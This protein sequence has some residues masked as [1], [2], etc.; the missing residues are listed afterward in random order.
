LHRNKPETRKAAVEAA[1]QL[2]RDLQAMTKTS[3]GA[4]C[5]IIAL[6]IAGSAHAQDA[7]V[8]A[9][10]NELS[11][12]VVTAQRTNQKLQDVPVSVT[13]VGAEEITRKQINS[14]VDLN[15]VAPNVQFDTGTGGTTSLKPYIRGGGITDGGFVLSESEV[16]IYI[17]DIYQPRLSAGS[18]DMAVLDRIEV[19][20]GPQ[21][22]LY[23]RNSSAGAVNFIT[24]G[25]SDTLNGF[26]ELGYGT[27]NERRAKAYVSAP[28]DAEGKWRLSA[29]G[30]VRARDG[31]MQYNETLEKKVGKNNFEGGQLDL[32]YVTDPVNIRLTGFYTH[33]GGDGQYAVNTQLNAAGTAYEPISGSYR[34][35]LSPIHSESSTTQY[36]SRLH[37]SFAY[38]GGELRSITGY[39]RMKE[40]WLED[41]SGGY[42]LIPNA[43]PVAL[44]VRD[45][46]SKQWQLSQETQMAGSVGDAFDYVA[47]VYYFHEQAEQAA[48][49]TTFFAPTALFYKPKTDSFAGYAQGTAHL[50][51][52]LSVILAGRYTID[53]KDLFGSVCAGLACTGRV[54]PGGDSVY[55][56]N[57]YRKFTPKAGIDFKVT[58]DVLLYASFSEGFKSGGYNGLAGNLTQLATPFKPQITKAYEAGVKSTLFGRKLRLNIAGFWNDIKDRQQTQN[59]LDGSFIVVNYNVRI[60]GIEAEAS[61]LVLPGLTIYGNG[62]INDGKYTGSSS[63]NAAL[64]RNDPPELPDYQITV[65]GDYT[66]EI[67]PGKF[68]LGADFRKTDEYYSTADNALIGFVQPR[69]ILNGY[70]SYAYGPVT[71]QLTG[72]NLT[73]KVK[74]QT[75]FGFATVNPQY[76]I[77]PRTLLGT[78]RYSF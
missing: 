11:D 58:P 13:A 40:S 37:M 41:L 25:P 17:D 62:A 26:L 71:L 59:N 57:T 53:D 44:F 55:L 61:L 56:H 38:P 33:N 24:K 3:L 9:N 60:R 54:G 69:S 31:G 6:S 4:M 15:R 73:N 74:P 66:A 32:A 16:A 8:D 65:G 29:N 22:V 70:V 7:V 45:M 21:G 43:P 30:M 19:L 5:S 46:G 68:G 23:G 77:E 52:A 49:T 78:V 42:P 2:M 10:A 20:R 35:V 18:V 36:G 12:I 64:L 47:G 14:A 67:G 27:W 63:A 34:R 72:K 39:S 51:D 75:G 50:T 48:V 28:L 1:T 76:V